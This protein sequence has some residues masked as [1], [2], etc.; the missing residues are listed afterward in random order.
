MTST[1]IGVA[2]VDRVSLLAFISS[3]RKQAG[4]ILICT[5]LEIVNGPVCEMIQV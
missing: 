4:K 2:R 3:E 5:S 1:T